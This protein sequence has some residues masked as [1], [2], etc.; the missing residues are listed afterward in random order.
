MTDETI[1][2]ARTDKSL[3]EFYKRD[4][5]NSREQVED[6]ETKYGNITA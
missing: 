5:N 6:M 4:Q 3:M 1:E 2:V